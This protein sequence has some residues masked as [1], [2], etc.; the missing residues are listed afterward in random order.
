MYPSLFGQSSLSEMLA[1]VDKLTPDFAPQWGKMNFA[2]ML[3]QNNVGFDIANGKIPVSYNFLMR[4]MLK[5][6]VKSKVIGNK[7]YEKNSRAAP[8]FVITDE[9]DFAKGKAALM[10]NFKAFHSEGAG[11]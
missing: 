9:W 8:A 4:F 5:M 2:Q 6:M 10:A 3:A 7:P 1:R 11:V